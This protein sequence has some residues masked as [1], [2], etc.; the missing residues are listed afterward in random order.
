MKQVTKFL[1]LGLAM[2]LGVSSLSGC[3]ATLEEEDYSKTVVATYGDQ[4]IYLDEANFNARYYQ[5]LYESFYGSYYGSDFWS[6]DTGSG[7]MEENVKENI[8]AEILQTYVLL[9]HA[10]EYDVSLSDADKEKVES[11]VTDFLDSSDENLIEAAKATEELVTKIYTN[12][13]LANKVW[14]AV[15]DGADTEVSD[16]DARQV[17]VKYVLISED[18]ETYTDGE[19]TA[20]EIADKVKAGTDIDTVCEDYD[21]LSATED[22]YSKNGDNDTDLGKEAATLST[23]ETVTYQLEGTGWYVIYCT[24]DD[25]KEAAETAK[26]EIIEDRQTELFETTY[27][28]WSKK[29]FKVDEDV[30][31]E[32]TFAKNMI[33]EVETEAETTSE[34]TTTESSTESTTETV[35]TEA[36]TK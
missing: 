4:N 9:E 34:A 10:D 15:V 24:T 21:N 27:S 26:E 29:K 8:M 5:Y 25:D 36:E 14:Q 12:N 7:T 35:T 17:T 13:A 28:G 22:S 11:A 6:T 18:D 16:E 20:T 1:S 33:Y 19:A 30:W 32:I 23:G 2:T 31:A 3:T